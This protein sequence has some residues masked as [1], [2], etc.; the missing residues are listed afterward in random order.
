MQLIPESTELS[1]YLEETEVVNFSHPSIQN[2]RHQLFHGK[3]ELE[4]VEAAFHFVRD[5]I[6]HSW[7]IQSNR[8]T[9][10]AS[11]VLQFKEGICYAKANLLAALLR[12]EGIPTGFCYQRLTIFDT[13]EQGYCLHT[14]NGVY[15]QPLKRWIRLDA[16]GNKQGVQAEFSIK[17]EKLAF[18]IREQ[19]DEKDYPIIYTKPNEKTITALETNM[20]IRQLYTNHLPDAL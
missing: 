4:K 15:I 10:K 5:E 17:E 8:I 18:E 2:V 1:N 12:A 6:S 16:R 11:D 13:P 20:E 9:C 3:T 19:F 7:D 14:L